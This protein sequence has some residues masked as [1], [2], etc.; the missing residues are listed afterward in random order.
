M[1]QVRFLLEKSATMWIDWTTHNFPFLIL[2]NSAV[3]GRDE[4]L[5]NSK[6]FF[7]GFRV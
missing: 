1:I 3:G 2:S 5:L 6:P 4:G 7:V